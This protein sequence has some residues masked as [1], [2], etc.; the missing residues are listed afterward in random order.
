MKEMASAKKNSEAANALI[1]AGEK[2]NTALAEEREASRLFG[3]AQDS[4]S[5]ERKNLLLRRQ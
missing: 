1:Y 4:V 5:C 2:Y 3:L